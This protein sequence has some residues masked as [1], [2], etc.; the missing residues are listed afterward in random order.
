MNDT[1]Y[2]FTGEALNQSKSLLKIDP[3]NIVLI[4]EKV[5]VV[6]TNS[7]LMIFNKKKIDA[8]FEEGSNFLAS[9]LIFMTFSQVANFYLFYACLP[10][11]LELYII[12]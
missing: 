11:F 3:R 1:E 4:L 9:L 5:K 6:M 2:V 10:L 8:F 12:G 7:I